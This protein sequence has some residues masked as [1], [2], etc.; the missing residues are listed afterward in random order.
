MNTTRARA[1]R[2]VATGGQFVHTQKGAPALELLSTEKAAPAFA[3]AHD[4]IPSQADLAEQWPNRRQRLDRYNE[5]L[6]AYATHPLRPTPDRIGAARRAVSDTLAVKGEFAALSHD[7]ESHDLVEAALRDERM[8]T[9]A[10]HDI[11]HLALEDAHLFGER[12]A[13]A[14]Y[15]A[16]VRRR[17][18]VEPP[19]G[20]DFSW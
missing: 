2:G 19:E 17:D 3:D 20:D 14:L 13:G 18:G 5:T 12:L 10:V 7:P 15:D 9:N 6:Y 11:G 1:P 16:Q 4:P 8:V